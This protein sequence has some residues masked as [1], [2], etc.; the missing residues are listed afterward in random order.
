[1]KFLKIQKKGGFPAPA[2]QKTGATY[3]NRHTNKHN[4]HTHTHTH[5]HTHAH[6]HTNTFTIWEDHFLCVCIFFT[7]K[8]LW[9]VQKFTAAIHN[10]LL[11]F[12]CL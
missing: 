12:C 5:T 2:S 1:M 10:L 11:I 6:T 8:Y 7:D 4:I 3:T 9:I